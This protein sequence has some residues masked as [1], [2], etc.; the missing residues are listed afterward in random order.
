MALSVYAYFTASLIGR[1]YLDMDDKPDAP[2]YQSDMYF[3]FFASL[4]FVFYVGWLKVAETLVNPFGEDDDDFDTNF[5]VDRN[6][7][8]CFLLIDQVGRFPP[9]PEKDKF[10]TSSVPKELPYTVASLPFRPETSLSGVIVTKEKSNNEGEELKRYPSLY[11]VV[12]GIK[13]S[14]F[15]QN[16]L[17]DS[18][19]SYD[20]ADKMR[21]ISFQSTDGS[22][23]MRHGAV[24]EELGHHH[25]L[26]RL[27]IPGTIPEVKEQVS[28]IL[29]SKERKTLTPDAIK[30]LKDNQVGYS[31]FI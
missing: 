27:A 7:Q 23:N 14:L 30:R 4:E 16:S 15:R 6:I 3:P 1:Q 2:A 12:S 31:F 5:L 20:H 25:Y 8:L 9:E 26:S 10:W 11:S 18:I 17:T 28:P 22:H 24:Q 29:R 19:N 21:R 13:Q